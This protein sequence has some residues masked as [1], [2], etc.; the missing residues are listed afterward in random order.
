MTQVTH[1]VKKSDGSINKIAHN[2]EKTDEGDYPKITEDKKDNIQEALVNSPDPFP[3]LSNGSI[4]Y[5]SKDTF[6]VSY[7]LFEKNMNDLKDTYDKLRNVSKW[8]ANGEDISILF[9]TDG[10]FERDPVYGQKIVV[11]TDAKV[12]F[13]GDIHSSLHSF[14]NCL[15]N[16]NIFDNN[17]KITNPKNYLIFTGDII[18]R[19]PY[20]IELLHIIFS[21]RIKNPNNVYICNGN[22]EDSK[23]YNS[24]G[25]KDEFRNQFPSIDQTNL[26][27]T[28]YFLPTVLFLKFIG[29]D[30]WYQFNHGMF[31]IEELD[32]SSNKY[33][34]QSP[35][36]FLESEKQFWFINEHDFSNGYKWFD[37]E[38]SDDPAEIEEIDGNNITFDK[39]LSKNGRGIVINSDLLKHYL[40][41]NKIKTIISGHQDIETNLI[42]LNENIITDDI[43]KFSQPDFID[44]QN[45]GMVSFKKELS[46][47]NFKTYEIE[48][49]KVN[50]FK[51]STA[52][53][54]KHLLHHAYGLIANEASEQGDV[55]LNG[56]CNINLIDG[57]VINCDSYIEMVEREEIVLDSTEA[58]IGSM[59]SRDDGYIPNRTSFSYGDP[60]DDE[61][62]G[63]E[64]GSNKYIKIYNY[65]IK[66]LM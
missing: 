6:L 1:L 65:L 18:D 36:E 53:I 3:L 4:S 41:Y 26:D 33:Y 49:K 7:D 15:L 51:T 9:N 52:T 35:K 2:E 21:L 13:I 62:E 20:S 16:M 58:D 12:F 61:V 10:Y 39:N 14:W 30:K 24:Y 8:K 56:K 27:K 28:L 47:K 32:L 45:L 23:M 59:S 48:S 42:V 44:Y 43:I 63:M 22:H 50:L 38:Q 11:P 29:E 55:F 37:F 57:T 40:D 19:G 46:L 25:F 60:P 54:A 66:R 31:H 64:G 34:I 5:K 17:L